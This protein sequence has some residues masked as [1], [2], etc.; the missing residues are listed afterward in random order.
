MHKSFTKEEINQA[1]ST[2]K[3]KN[4]IAKSLEIS[5]PTLVKWCRIYDIDY[6][7]Y[8]PKE[9]AKDAFVTKEWL[10][11]HWINSNKSLPQL[12]KEFHL[13]E[14]LLEAR[15]AKY[16][17]TKRFKYPLNLEKLYNL[18]D[19]NVYYLAGLIATD[20]YI[21]QGQDAVEISL[22]GDSELSLL[23]D[24]EQYLELDFPIANYKGSYRLRIVAP[25]LEEF[26]FKAFNIPA[27]NKTFAVTVPDDF[28]NESCAKAYVRGC[29]DGDGSI[30]TTNH[31]GFSITTASEDFIRGLCNIFHKYLNES[32]PYYFEKRADRK[33]PSINIQKRRARL[34]LD[35]VYSEPGLR[36]ERKYQLYLKVNDIV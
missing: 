28:P 36:L 27:L 18:N 31:L 19:P 16:G 26:L 15:R 21:P 10:I 23:T 3:L 1:F 24:I 34:I 11:D 29:L 7:N 25:G 4:E 8:I 13:T 32:I 17:L 5:V 33:Y 22:T 6:K 35:W 9:K 12:A 2:G 20:G 14:G 30:K